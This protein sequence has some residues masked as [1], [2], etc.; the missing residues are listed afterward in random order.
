ML[1]SDETLQQLIQSLWPESTCTFL[2]TIG[3]LKVL[4]RR[5]RHATSDITGYQKTPV[6]VHEHL[7]ALTSS[8]QTEGLVVR[9]GCDKTQRRGGKYTERSRKIFNRRF[10]NWSCTHQMLIAHFL[11]MHT[12][13]LQTDLQQTRQPL[14]SVNINSVWNSVW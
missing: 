3:R 6:C 12:V 4:L 10:K 7:F 8:I 2:P 9:V 11:T 1:Q 13:S 5:M 14:V